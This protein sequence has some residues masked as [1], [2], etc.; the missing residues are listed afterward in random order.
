[1]TKER[2]NFRDEG[3][4]LILGDF[5]LDPPD[6]EFAVVMG[7]TKVGFQT[8][9]RAAD[10]ADC[11]CM[12]ISSLV[13]VL[14]LHGPFDREL[15]PSGNFPNDVRLFAIAS[16]SFRSQPRSLPTRRNYDVRDTRS[17]NPLQ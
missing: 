1:M 17:N 9:A 15:P 7:E 5:R 14:Q 11:C 8:T 13:N 3:A 6:Q 2:P 12:K 10:V 4:N 16:T